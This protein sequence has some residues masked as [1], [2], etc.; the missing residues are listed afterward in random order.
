MVN[1]CSSSAEK[2]MVPLQMGWTSKIRGTAWSVMKAVAVS[3]LPVLAMGTVAYVYAYRSS[4]AAVTMENM[5]RADDA[6]KSLDQFMKERVGDMEVLGDT[7]IRRSG[8]VH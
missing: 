5:E 3:A 4:T 2:N 8:A 1:A 7:D 6:A